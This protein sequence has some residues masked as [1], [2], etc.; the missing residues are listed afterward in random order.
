VHHLLLALHSERTGGHAT[1]SYWRPLR[2]KLLQVHFSLQ[3]GRCTARLPQLG[4]LGGW[5]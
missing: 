4:W 2:L 3:T 5:L 1:V